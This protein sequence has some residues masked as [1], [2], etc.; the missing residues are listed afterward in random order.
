MTTVARRPTAAR[1]LPDLATTF[2]RWSFTRGLCARGY[3][4]V[5]SLYL[6]V[7]ADLSPSELVLADTVS[8]KWSLVLAHVVTGTGMVLAG[9]VTT[10][11]ALALS[12]ALWG[13][14]WAFAS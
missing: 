13:L 1:P 8:R 4:L 12:Q 10:F 9:L 5:A 11:P 2:L 6:V 3:W 7:V 14:G